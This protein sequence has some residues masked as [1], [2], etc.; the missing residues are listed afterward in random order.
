MVVTDVGQT[1]YEE[2]NYLPFDEAI[3]A[4]FGW[5]IYEGHAAYD[6]AT[7]DLSERRFRD[8]GRTAHLAPVRLLARRRLRSHRRT[9]HRRS[10]PAGAERKADLGRLLLRLGQDG[11]APDRQLHR[12]RFAAQDSVGKGA[13]CTAQR[14]RRRPLPAAVSPDQQRRCPDAQ[15]GQYAAPMNPLGSNLEEAD[16]KTIVVRNPADGETV[17]VV[18]V[19][20][21]EQVAATVARVR[22]NQPEWE[23]LGF[24]RRA[25][26]L[27]RLR[28]WMLDNADLI[29]DLMQAETG[30][31]RAEAGNEA[32]YLADQIN[33]WNRANARRFAGE[34]RVLGHSLLTI[35]RKL[36]IQY[37]PYPVV[38]LISPWN[39]PLVLSLGDAIPA[40]MA[41]AAVVMKPSEFTPLATEKVVDAW[42][43]EIGGPDV[44]AVV[45]G[46]A[47]TATALVDEAD[48]LGFTGSDRVGKLVMARAAE[49]LTPVSLE[50]GGKDPMVVMEG[51]NIDRAASAAAWG[52]MMNSG[53]ICMSV[54]RI[55]VEEPVYDEFVS[56]LTDR[57]KELRQG[58][59]GPEFSSEIGA[60]TSPNQ[61]GVVAGQVS[62]AIEHGARALTGGRP[63]DREGDY[64][65]PT[66]LVDVD[67]S[68][69]VMR[70]E[71]FGPVVGVMKVKDTEEA[72]HLANDTRYGLSATVFGPRRKAEQVARRIECGGVNVNDVI[73]NVMVPGVPM[74][75]WRESGIGNRNGKAGIRKYCRAEAIVSARVQFLPEPF[76]FPYTP[77]RRQSVSK[78]TRF[79]NARG[80]RN[81]LGL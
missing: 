52:G 76:W 46:A 45:Q 67:H 77:E 80:I 19:A 79:V 15:A 58:P 9:G 38:G 11:H 69:R 8:S 13:A 17:A 33:F 75:G 10:G 57:V 60:M 1:R 27:G 65:E 4:N 5:K 40:L 81:R 26:W 2:V 66:V 35:S 7:E 73:T 74:G 25:E 20:T 22:A 53:Q 49:T 16:L 36:R 64:F 30:K 23:Q 34:E 18:D 14:L 12:C 56:K 37:R 42:R 43:D 68:M 47:E 24:R 61:L 44:L 6:C 29:T 3:G 70:D 41:G 21:P 39:F 71:T 55:Y 72:V 50:L 51:A 59:D 31:V 48:F 32:F 54:E 63:A 62:E 28:D 78:L